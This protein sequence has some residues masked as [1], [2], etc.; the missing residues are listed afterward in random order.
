MGGIDTRLWVPE[1]ELTEGHLLGWLPEG[2][3][4]KIDHGLRVCC[5]L[6]HDVIL[7]FKGMMT[8]TE[9]QQEVQD[10]HLVL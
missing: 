5:Q 9:N 1:D 10:P 7:T 4:A 6:S 8:S 2:V 3:P